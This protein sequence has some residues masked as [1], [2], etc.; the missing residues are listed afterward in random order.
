MK[1]ETALILIDIWL[2]ET[3]GRITIE[4]LIHCLDYQVTG[5]DLEGAHVPPG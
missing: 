3:P 1:S 5:G 2:V 4:L